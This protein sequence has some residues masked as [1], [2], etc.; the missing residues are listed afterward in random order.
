MEK[1]SMYRG[2]PAMARRVDDRGLDV[3]GEGS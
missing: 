1:H 2:P 3:I